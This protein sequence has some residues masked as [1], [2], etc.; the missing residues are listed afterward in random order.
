PKWVPFFL[1]ES[2]DG[3]GELLVSLQ[4]IHTKSADLPE[5]PKIVPETRPAYLDMVI[6][7]IR[8]L[9][10]YNYLPMQL[11]YCVFEVDDMDGTK[12]SLQTE[13]S[14]KPSGSNANFLK[15]VKMKL[16]LPR[17]VTYA[18]RVKIRVYDTRLGGYKTPLVG[19][20]RIDL[21]DKLPWAEGYK[22]PLSATFARDQLLHAVGVE[23]EDD[24]DQ[25]MQEAAG[26]SMHGPVPSAG[27]RRAGGAGAGVVWGSGSMFFSSDGG[28]G[29]ND[30]VSSGP[31]TDRG[32][33]GAFGNLG[34]SGFRRHRPG[35][36]SQ[37][38]SLLGGT[39]QTVYTPD[40]VQLYKARQRS[41]TLTGTTEF[42]GGAAG[43]IGVIRQRNW[44]TPA[45]NQCI[46][47]ATGEVVDTG[48]GVMPALD[49]ARQRAGLPT[50]S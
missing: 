9:Q 36:S 14:N 26:S 8:D 43:A 6:L 13:T 3:Q 1:E 49:A 18:P 24:E 48:I 10:P 21:T 27:S 16:E 17:E 50:S 29:D 19:S 30:S 5:P 25:M 42:G 40:N 33:Q 35:L 44:D 34:Q 23:T 20:G 12:R 11:P 45:N 22:P 37:G 15:R 2:G 46:V 4:I 47:S 41:G 31:D 28:D 7:G 32:G 38:S 39:R